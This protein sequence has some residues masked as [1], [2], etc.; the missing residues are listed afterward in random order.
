MSELLA[1]VRVIE[2][3]T[4]RNGDNVGMLL[5]DLGADV[6]KVESPRRG[7]HLRAIGGQITPQ[8]S[9]AH[10]QFNRNKRSVALDLRSPAGTAAFWRLLDTADVFVDGYVAGACDR[11]GIGYKA[12]RERN[13]GIV[14]CQH[15][16]F[17]A[18]SPYAAIPT[19]GQMMDAL[20][21]RFPTVRGDDGFLHRVPLTATP[22]GTQGGGDPTLVGALYAVTYILAALLRRASTGSGTYIDVAGADAAVTSAS[23]VLVSEIN[24]HR[25]TK[26]AGK[27]RVTN[28]ENVSARYQIYETRDG[29]AVMFCA[30]EHTFWE[31]FCD[32]VGRP[33]LLGSTNRETEVDFGND[34]PALRAELSRI[35]AT[36]TL[37]EWLAVA[38]ANDIPIGPAHQTIDDLR[39]DDHFRTREVFVDG[40]HPHAG[41]FTYIGRPA[42]IDGDRFEIHHPAPLLG[43]HTSE[44]LTEIGYTAEELDRMRER[45]TV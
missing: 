35:F 27:A 25:V 20:A 45:G 6:I 34:L 22:T 4:L 2:C 5:G 32:V 28:G 8:H 42:L 24:A 9:S 19:H 14:Y 1:G 17:G 38:V 37:D 44:V 29:R 15:S 7:D 13:P 10:I 12:Q 16:G 11:L 31:H 21:G 30:I 23:T 3:A 40:V 43:E 33:D 36:R 41:A 39:D 18:E 26:H